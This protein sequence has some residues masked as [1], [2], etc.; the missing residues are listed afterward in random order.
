MYTFSAPEKYKKLVEAYIG[1]KATS[2][3]HQ[4]CYV[5]FDLLSSSI[6]KEHASYLEVSQEKNIILLHCPYLN[7]AMGRYGI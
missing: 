5:I 1:R 2:G 3:D 4:P 7:P 6:L